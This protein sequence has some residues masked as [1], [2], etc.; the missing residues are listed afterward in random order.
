MRGRNDVVRKTA[1]IWQ[2]YDRFGYWQ[3]EWT[4][5]DCAEPD[6]VKPAL[7]VIGNVKHDVVKTKLTLNLRALRL[8]GKSAANAP[9]GRTLSLHGNTLALRVR[10]VSFLLAK[11][12]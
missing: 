2:T 8:K 11:A 9:E 4:P 5:Y 6:L 12:R 1:N 3:A 7:L 10:P